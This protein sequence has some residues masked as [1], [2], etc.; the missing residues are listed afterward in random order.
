AGMGMMGGVLN[1]TRNGAL[2]AAALSGTLAAAYGVSRFFYI[3]SAR[4]R[5][6][7]LRAVLQRVVARAQESLNAPPETPRFPRR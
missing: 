7:E 3:R 1:A 2:A 5:E 6:K 4:K